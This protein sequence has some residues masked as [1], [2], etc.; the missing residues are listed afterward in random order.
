MTAVRARIL[1]SMRIGMFAR[2]EFGHGFPALAH[3]SSASR[4]IIARRSSGV[5]VDRRSSVPSSA[6][7]ARSM[8]Q[9]GSRTRKH[10][11]GVSVQGAMRSSSRAWRACVLAGALLTLGASGTLAGCARPLT[12][13]DI[14]EHGTKP[15]P[16]RSPAQVVR[17]STVALRTLGYEVVVADAASGRIKTAPKLMQ[18]Y[19]V[20]SRYSATTVA[21]ALAWTIDITPARGGAVVHAHPRAYANGALQ[22]DGVMNA[23]YMEKAFADL[24]REIESNLPG[25]APRASGKP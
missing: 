25:A 16:G 20:G 17:A 3:A 4:S 24:F 12:A 2:A 9:Q 13:A 19:A 18:V 1:R 14:E 21:N 5:V 6:K 8:G 15:F 10:G 11:P 23:E 22:D 7:A